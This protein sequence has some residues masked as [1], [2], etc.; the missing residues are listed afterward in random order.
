MRNIIYII[1]FFTQT[2]YTLSQI[3]SY[4]LS[5]SWSKEQVSQLYDQYGIPEST[6]SINYAVDGY[7]ILYQTPDYNGELVLCSG[8]MF[9]P[10]ESVPE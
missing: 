3:M 9:L 8:A 4:E 1:A 2:T 6:G 5:E 10:A 7:K